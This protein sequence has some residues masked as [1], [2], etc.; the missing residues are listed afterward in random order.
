MN[1][2]QIIMSVFIALAIGMLF[3]CENNI[4]T[5]QKIMAEDT[6]AEATATHIQYKRTDSGR[7]Q[8]ILQSPLL[9]KF[10]GKQPYTEFPK[11]FHIKFYDRTGKLISTLTANYGIRWEKK[12]LL[13]ARNQVVVK[14]LKSGEQLDTENLSWDE[15]KEKIYS[16]SFVKISS[17]DRTIFGDSLVANQTFSRRTIYGIRGVMDIKEDSIP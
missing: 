6:L 15:K 10:G 8:M 17:P 5:V 14:N 4:Q 7:V 3:S 2:I 13:Q 12:G 16:H 11:G 1:R 9:L